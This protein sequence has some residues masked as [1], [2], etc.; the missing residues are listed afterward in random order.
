LGLCLGR[1][2]GHQRSYGQ[3]PILLWNLI[4]GLSLGKMLLADIQVLPEL[5][6]RLAIFDRAID[7]CM[8]RYL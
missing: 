6:N 3:V 7:C 2:A 1:F 4:P 5:L 8:P